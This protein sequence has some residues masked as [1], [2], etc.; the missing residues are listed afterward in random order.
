VNN[1]PDLLPND[2][3]N[4]TLL[5]NV[6]PADW[7]N[8]TPQGRYNLVVI[9]GG[10]AGLITAIGAAGLGAKVALIERHFLGGDCLNHGCVPSKGIIGAARVAHTIRE[11]AR[12]GMDVP[13]GWKINFGAAMERMRR[14]RSEI[15]AHDSAQRFQD[16]GV[17]VFLGAARFVDDEHVAVADTQLHFKKAVIATGAR[18][19]VPPIPGLEEA[20]YL[21]NE[22]VFSLT[23]RPTRMVIVGGGPIGCELAQAF[24]RLGTQVTVIDMAPEILPREDAD[25]GAIVRAS[26]D[27][28]G[29]AF[30]TGA[31]IKSVAKTGNTTQIELDIDGELSKVETDTVL[32]AVGRAPNVDG[33]NLDNVGVQYTPQQGIVVDDTLRSTN[34]RIYACGDVCQRYKFTHAADA[35][36]RIVIRN[37]LF[38]FRPKSK[39][40][41]LVIPW[42]TYTAPE[43]A[44]VGLSEEDAKTQGIPIDTITVAMAENDRAQLDGDTD[45]LLKIHVAK[46]TDRILG[47][48]LVSA[49]AGE[50]IGEL[51][52]AITQKI[53]LG[54]FAG[55]IHPYPTQAEVFKRAGDAMMRKKFKPWIAR[56]FSR[57]ITWQR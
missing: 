33:M 14:I 54:K 16:L 43:I 17:D 45:G 44:H 31:A 18:A 50:S 49:H 9:G 8:P 30:L 11:S 5:D 35:A 12:F 1:I 3:H 40:S 46:G 20:G 55:V 19:F 10:T 34:P 51:T 4:Q 42:V 52:L 22:T 32:I 7:Q 24:Q 27:H 36:A 38:P 39:F 47:G 28:D 25:A 57:I 15:S 23:E 26:M 13:D 56:L 41:K 29:V 2:T 21:T 48:T 37:T 6:H 53:G